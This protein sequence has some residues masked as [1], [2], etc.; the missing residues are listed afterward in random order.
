[1]QGCGAGAGAGAFGAWQ[2]SRSRSL[3]AGAVA[4]A[5]AFEKQRGSAALITGMRIF[6]LLTEFPY[7]L[8][9]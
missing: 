1:M 9:K 3:Q 6:L 2:F 4:G 8:L 5:G 7:Q